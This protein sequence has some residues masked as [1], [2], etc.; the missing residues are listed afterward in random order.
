MKLV[1]HA[2]ITSTQMKLL[3]P[4]FGQQR[5]KV[6]SDREEQR[7]LLAVQLGHIYEV[8]RLHFTVLLGVGFMHRP[9]A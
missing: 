4:Q 7:K 5:C 1:D 2:L 9:V 3:D 8:P 6:I